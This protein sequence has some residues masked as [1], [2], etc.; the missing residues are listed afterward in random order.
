MS[1]EEELS[2]ELKKPILFKKNDTKKPEL[3]KGE[4]YTK[5]VDF[6]NNIRRSYGDLIK[7]VLIFG[8][9]ATGQMK[10]TSDADIWV[11]LDDTATKSSED[12]EKVQLQVQLLA[13]QMK[14]IHVQTTGLTEFWGWMK[15]GSPELFNYL[16]VGLVV[17]DTGFVKPVQRMLKAGLLPPSD[18][19]VS[20][21]IRS[22]DAH[23]KK[24][25]LTIKSMI[26]DLR[27]AAT[28]AC[29]SVVMYYCKTT[30][31]Q[32]HMAEELN[33][34][35]KEKKLEPEYINK[36]LELDAL[37]KDIEHEKIKDVNAEHLNKAIG[38]AASI[39]EKM[40]KLLPKDLTESDLTL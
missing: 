28:D 18:E 1:F 32:K 5:I 10:K 4:I 36:F 21:K 16:R 9:A 3:P 2:Q 14:D 19:T 24:V 25:S 22:A 15:K 6:T 40:K 30:P 31:D 34:L 8:S 17:H 27:Y 35:V 38:L 11:I 20:I 37:W 29:Q 7:S 33:K 39:I 23:L 13:G 12:L 26:F